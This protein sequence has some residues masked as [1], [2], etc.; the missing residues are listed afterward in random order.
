[1]QE[2]TEEVSNEDDDEWEY[3]EEG[4]PEI[5]WQGNEI[6]VKKNKVKVK[7][8]EANQ[9]IQKEVHKLIAFSVFLTAHNHTTSLSNFSFHF[10]GS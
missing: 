3:I 6:I 2:G 9:S 10:A 5:I 4:P 8:K 1:M 7:K